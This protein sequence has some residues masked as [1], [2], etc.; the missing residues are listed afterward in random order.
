ME[1]LIKLDSST[2]EFVEEANEAFASVVL[3]PAYRWAKFVLT[4]DKVNLNRQRIP[5]EEFPNLISS[6]IF[7]P[8]KMAVNEIRE[9]HSESLPIGVI[10]NLI[11]QEDRVIGLAA[12]W[13]KEREEDVEYLRTLYKDK[14]PLNLS[15]EIY[16]K[17]ASKEEDDIEVLKGTILK[18]ATLV[19]LPAYGGR[20]QIL[21]MASQNSEV[22]LNEE[23]IKALQDKA[24]TLEAKVTELETA[25]TARDTELATLKTTNEELATY[26]QTVEAEKAS[27]EKLASVKAKFAEAKIEKDEN[28][29]EANKEM[30]LKLDEAG[31]NFLIQELVSFKETLSTSSQK[32]T[33]LPKFTT[34][35]EGL[36]PVELGRQMRESLYKRE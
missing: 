24:Q 3:N 11:E 26:K 10:T 1:T 9:D 19:G 31:L 18:A 14:K 36:N 13:A 25:L 2:L 15:W 29:F 23:E 20:T 35:L 33:Q 6:G 7:A 27:V 5:K 30:L 8:I 22:T 12:L 32:K 34:D 21:T 28:Y 16:Y 17:E 4:D